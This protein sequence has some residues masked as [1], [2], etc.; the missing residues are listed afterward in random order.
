RAEL[1]HHRLDPV[2]MAVAQRQHGDAAQ[3]VEVLVALVVPEL[4]ALAAHE[5]D[6]L[7]HVG[8]HDRARLELLQLGEA[9]GKTLVPMPLSVKSSSSSECGRRAAP[10]WA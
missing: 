2:G 3:E 5:L 9:H 8:G 7:A 6:R 4:R 10:V 1:V